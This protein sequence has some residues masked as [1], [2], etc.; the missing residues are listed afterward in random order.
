M[1]P[2]IAINR[3]TIIFFGS[4]G[5]LRKQGK[6]RARNSYSFQAFIEDF[7]LSSGVDGRGV[8]Y[9]RARIS[10]RSGSL[11]PNL[12][13]T[14]SIATKSAPFL[15]GHPKRVSKKSP[16]LLHDPGFSRHIRFPYPR[17]PLSVGCMEYP[18]T[19]LIE[20][21]SHTATNTGSH[22]S[23]DRARFGIITSWISSHWP[24]SLDL[25]AFLGA[26]LVAQVCTDDSPDVYV[27]SSLKSGSESD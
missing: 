1:S 7:I 22:D 17:S 6:N 14:F 10:P 11:Q 12:T 5:C 13:D 18:D 2:W 25:R 16:H 20:P 19:F 15:W 26:A 23:T 3:F 8:D 21:K 24:L 9:R 4:L 27:R